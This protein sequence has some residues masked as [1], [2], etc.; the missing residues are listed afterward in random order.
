M[1]RLTISASALCL[2]LTV[3]LFRYRQKVRRQKATFDQLSASISAFL[4][5]PVRSDFS[6]EE[7]DTAGLQNSIALLEEAYL[8]LYSLLKEERER[9]HYFVADISHQLKTPL[10]GLKLY[11]ELADSGSREKEMLLIERMEKLIRQLLRMERLRAGA[12]EF[13]FETVDLAA[14]VNEIGLELSSLYP[15]HRISVSGKA[16]L[17]VDPIWMREALFNVLKNSCDQEPGQRPVEVRLNQSDA[18][19]SIEVED[20]C[21]GLKNIEVNHLFDRFN[22]IAPEDSMHNSGL[23]LAITKAII[24][25]HH[26]SIFAVNTL[27]GLKTSICLPLHDGYQSY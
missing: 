15:E 27:T 25:R 10:S 20:F 26:G 22:R 2:F 17:R 18:V 1:I 8:Q 4:A 13:R 11:A 5:D 21:G 23:G 6:L 16:V 24:E 7:N 19:V 14:L 9:N 3:L 12:Y